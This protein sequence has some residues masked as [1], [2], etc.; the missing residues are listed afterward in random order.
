MLKGAA[1]GGLCSAYGAGIGV[2]NGDAGGSDGDVFIGGG[3]DVFIGGG[4]DVFIGGGGDVF[5]GCEGDVF[6]GCE[7][8]V[9]SGCEGKLPAATPVTFMCVPLA[10]AGFSGQDILAAILFCPGSMT[11]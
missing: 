11:A 6:S 8:D 9:F 4:G 1:D 3:G 2:G 5:S 7:G 10:R